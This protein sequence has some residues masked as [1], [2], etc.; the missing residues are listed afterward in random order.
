MFLVGITK[1][2]IDVLPTFNELNS[3]ITNLEPGKIFL[4]FYFN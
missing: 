3:Q 4:K 1:F 2:D